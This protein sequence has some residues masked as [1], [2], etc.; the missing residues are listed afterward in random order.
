[1]SCFLFLFFSF[2]FFCL[3][4]GW[5]VFCFL[6]QFLCVALAVLELTLQTRLALNSEICLPLPPKCWD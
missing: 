3:L 4:V 1:M 6:R 2:W 5:F